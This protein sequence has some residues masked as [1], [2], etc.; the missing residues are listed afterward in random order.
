MSKLPE[1]IDPHLV[2]LD[3]F[4]LQRYAKDAG[5]SR[6]QIKQKTGLALNTQ[7]EAF[8][9]NGLQR[10]KAFKLA[11]CLGKSVLELL[12]PW[13]SS[14]LPPMQPPGPCSAS[15]EWEPTRILQQGRPVPNGLYYIVYVM[16]HRHTANK[17]GRGKFYNLSWLPVSTRDMMKHQLSRH[18]D[19]CARVGIQPHIA[20]NHTSTPVSHYEGWWVIDDWV[21]EK[22]LA[23]HLAKP[24]PMEELPRLL[25]EI[26]RGLEALHDAGVIFREL[27]PT[28]VLLADK[29]GRAVLTDFELAKLE[30][31]PS[32]SSDWPEDP[33]L[34][35]EL[36]EGDV[37]VRADLYSLAQ[38]AAAAIAGPEFDIGRAPEILSDVE[39]P[40]SL[41]RLLV[42]ASQD[43]A[44][45]RPDKLAPILK[46]LANWT[47]KTSR[48]KAS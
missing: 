15:P 6:H 43:E 22:T 2:Y 30:G 41:K 4:L 31:S 39:M 45:R 3:P 29:D 9:G 18:G 16:R 7:A 35:P 12:A 47:E 5:L 11:K 26:A 1:N 37:T 40:R 23:D 14:Y 8:D 46:G 32:V 13:D 24:W 44:E 10:S 27:A 48:G 42:N 36:E 25:L 21:G 19:V 34:A 17:L 33:F 20:V 28:R 38:I